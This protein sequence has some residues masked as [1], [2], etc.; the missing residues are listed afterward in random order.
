M[1]PKIKYSIL[2]FKILNFITQYNTYVDWW[3]KCWPNEHCCSQLTFD[4]HE[5]ESVRGKAHRTYD[6][7][8][9]VIIFFFDFL[10]C[11]TITNGKIELSEWA[12]PSA[13]LQWYEEKREHRKLLAA[14]SVS[15]R[16]NVFSG[17]LS[18]RAVK[19]ECGIG[20]SSACFILLTFRWKICFSRTQ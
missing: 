18:W 16:I 1:Y 11:N 14:N 17:L 12:L 3:Q 5:F 6:I 19:S 10:I 4:K 20:N 15:N 13:E 2:Y 9:Q 7:G 8:Y